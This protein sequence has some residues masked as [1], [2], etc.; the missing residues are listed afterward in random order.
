MSRHYFPYR[1]ILVPFLA[2][3]LCMPSSLTR[4]AG[5]IDGE[6]CTTDQEYE[7]QTSIGCAGGYCNGEMVIFF[8]QSSCKSKAGGG[9]CKESGELIS[10]SHPPRPKFRGARQ[11][12]LCSGSTA[13]C[14][15]CA[16]AV[17]AASPSGVTAA[18]LALACGA[19]CTITPD[20]CC[21]NTC[22]PDYTRKI[23]RPGGKKC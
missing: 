14:L 3:A 1:L 2:V 18:A 22:V 7:V 20:P 19:L 16:A 8:E 17:A 21:Y 13:A 12:A 10:R 23:D 15:A 9:D 5:A 6:E 11:W 4:A